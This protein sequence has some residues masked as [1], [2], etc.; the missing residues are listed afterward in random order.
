MDEDKPDIAVTR[1]SDSSREQGSPVEANCTATPTASGRPKKKRTAVDRLIAIL[2]VL[3]TTM[4]TEYITT[5][6]QQLTTAGWKLKRADHDLI[7]ITNP[8]GYTT[9]MRVR[10]LFHKNQS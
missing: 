4:P 8:G 6:W 9:K 7:E 1:S 5:A 3:P 2:F 10:T